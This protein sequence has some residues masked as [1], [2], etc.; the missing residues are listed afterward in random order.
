MNQMAQQGFDR[1]A[2]GNSD[3]PIGVILEIA[4]SGSQIA[5]DWVSARKTVILP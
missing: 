5:L 2:A 1:G 3:R 4:G